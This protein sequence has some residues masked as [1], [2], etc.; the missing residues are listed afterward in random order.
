M[1]DWVLESTVD[2]P[3]ALVALRP[4][5]KAFQKYRNH[6]AGGK[7]GDSDVGLRLILLTGGLE[8]WILHLQFRRRWCHPMDSERHLVC[9]SLTKCLRTP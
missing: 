6:H 8:H 4:Q 1:N 5:L 2:D 9:F 3:L 7:K